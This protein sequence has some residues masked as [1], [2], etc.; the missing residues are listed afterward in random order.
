MPEARLTASVEAASLVRRATSTGDFAAILRKGDPDRGALVIIVRSRGE[1][2]AILE[3]SLGIDG[4]YH[5]EKSGPSSSESE[6]ELGEFLDKR[7]SFDPD[8]W[9]IE[10]DVAQA[11]RFIAETTGAA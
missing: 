4:T 8:L 2:V 10:L 9:L 11:E 3:R 5:W 7:V 6:R 1:Y